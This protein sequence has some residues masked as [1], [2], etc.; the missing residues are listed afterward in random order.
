MWLIA[1][2]KFYRARMAVGL[3]RGFGA[4]K[5]GPMGAG[6]L[7]RGASHDLAGGDGQTANSDSE[8]PED[9]ERAR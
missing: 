3:G 2:I 5:L 4:Q 6:A 7:C 8:L 1:S 9:E